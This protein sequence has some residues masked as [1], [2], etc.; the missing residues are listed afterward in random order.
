MDNECN[1][2]AKSSDTTTNN[3][4]CTSKETVVVINTETKNGKRKFI[5]CTILENQMT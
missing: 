4:P 3:V 2:V 5:F 1:E